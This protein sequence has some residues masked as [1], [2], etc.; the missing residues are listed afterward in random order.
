MLSDS[1]TPVGCSVPP[2][3]VIGIPQ[4]DA[5]EKGPRNRLPRQR[6]VQNRRGCGVK[7]AGM[8][9]ASSWLQ[10]ADKSLWKKSN[11][12]NIAI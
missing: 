6:L 11:N 10:I 1:T 7:K 5:D 3:G 4:K 9:S 2:L 8:V 12:P